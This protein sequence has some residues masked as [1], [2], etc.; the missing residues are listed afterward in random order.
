MR[1]SKGDSNTLSSGVEGLARL[2]ITLI[3][4]HIT[5][6]R[7]HF[8]TLMYANMHPLWAKKVQKLVKQLTFFFLFAVAFLQC[9]SVFFSFGV[10][11]K[12]CTIK[13]RVKYVC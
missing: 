7:V 1:H 5:T 4:L 10:T 9:F 8:N 12:L 3:T 2:H 13:P 6:L 11:G